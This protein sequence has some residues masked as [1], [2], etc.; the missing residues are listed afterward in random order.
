MLDTIAHCTE[1]ELLCIINK[2]PVDISVSFGNDEEDN[3]EK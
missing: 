3:E 1:I 2:Q